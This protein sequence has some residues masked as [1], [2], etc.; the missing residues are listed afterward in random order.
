ML[1]VERKDQ[2]AGW[3]SDNCPRNPWDKRGFVYRTLIWAFE[4]SS[5]ARLILIEDRQ[6]TPKIFKKYHQPSYGFPNISTSPA[7]FRDMP[8]MTGFQWKEASFRYGSNSNTV[9]ARHIH[10]ELVAGMIS[11]V[12][13]ERDPSYPVT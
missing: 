1:I 2:A 13:V 11:S 6:L 7:N 4:V 3:R 10:P 12:I 9:L 8:C 5:H